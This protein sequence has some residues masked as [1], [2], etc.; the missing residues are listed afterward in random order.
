[1]NK[2]KAA[3]DSKENTKYKKLC[4][5][6][7]SE[8]HSFN[9]SSEK[10]SSDSDAYYSTEPDTDDIVYETSEESDSVDREANIVVSTGPTWE[11][12]TG[13]SLRQFAFREIPTSPNINVASKPID[14]FDLF[15]TDEIYDLVV[16]QTNLNAHKKLMKNIKRCSRMR[17][18]KD[19]NT[20]EMKKFFGLVVYMG[21]VKLPGIHMYWS[22]NQFY[23]NAFVPQVMSRNRF[24]LLLKMIHFANDD[25][26]AGDR[27][28][29]VRNLLNLLEK[30][31]MSRTP[32]E[33]LVV[34]ESMIPWRGRLL[35]RQYNPRKSHRYGVKDYKLCDPSGYTYTSSIYCGASAHPQ[36]RGTP[37]PGSPHTS[38]IVLD[39]AE[40]YL[41]NGRTMITDNFY[42]SITLAKALQ[43]RKTHLIGTLRKDRTGNPETV[44]KSKLKRGEIVGRESSGIVVA[45]WKDKRD[46][47]MLTTK[48]NLKQKSTGKQGIDLSDQ[49]SSYFS[50]L[51][52]TIRWYHKIA[53]EYLLSTSVVNALILYKVVQPKTKILHFKMSICQSLCG[54]QTASSSSGDNQYQYMFGQLITALSNVSFNDTHLALNRPLHNPLHV[55]KSVLINA[56]LHVSHVEVKLV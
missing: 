6:E 15:V 53:F 12:V 49:M 5:R 22:K 51:R 29:K 43:N 36:D 52:K 4:V 56:F 38:Q 40:P 11:R 8:E 23:R 54:I 42:T 25:D 14:V 31:F 3:S 1:M 45:K 24:Q 46:V 19:T 21:I 47:L 2:R 30:N 32:G 48:H 27:L 13:K 33:I 50:P 17:K 18:W 20:D 39:L 55:I 28:G 44:T 16:T 41:D 7:S 26:I 9:E 10:S 34:D 37:K 35:F